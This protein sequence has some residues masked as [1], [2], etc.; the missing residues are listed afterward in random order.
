MSTRRVQQLSGAAFLLLAVFLGIHAFGLQY[1]TRLG[2][3]PGFFPRWLCAILAALSLAVILRASLAAAEEAPA[4]FYPD[5]V[6]ALRIAAIVVVLLATAFAMTTLGFR[7]TMLAFYLALLAVLGRWRW[8]E[9][10]LVAL[11]GSF[12]TYYAFTE[13]LSTPLPIGRFGI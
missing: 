2:P 5:R 6:G 13:W 3:G 8:T 10:P 9:S 4:D 7:L 11:L 12:G 1:Y